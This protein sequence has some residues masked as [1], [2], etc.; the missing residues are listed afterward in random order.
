MFSIPAAED[1]NSKV[2]K[3]PT[4][5]IDFSTSHSSRL[6][7]LNFQC[8]AFD[9]SNSTN[10]LQTRICRYIQ[11]SS[12]DDKVNRKAFILAITFL[13]EFAYPSCSLD[14]P[15][16]VEGISGGGVVLTFDDASI[17]EW[18]AVDSALAAYHWKA[19]FCV[20]GFPALDADHVNKLAALQA[21]GHEIA[22]HGTEHLDAVKYL[23][24]HSAHDYFSKE[25]RPSLDSMKA[26]GIRVQS[27][28]YPYGLRNIESDRVLMGCFSILRGTKSQGFDCL[29]SGERTVYAYEID[30]HPEDVLPHVF[31]LLFY[32]R[33]H[34]EIVIFYAHKP[35]PFGSGENIVNYQ[36]LKEICGFVTSAGM[37]F[38]TLRDLALP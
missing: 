32:A 12:S 37:Q 24:S 3:R 10:H 19:T 35:E 9:I 2:F 4:Y 25:I 38:L 30:G 21:G 14:P 17:D 16:A 26:H 34:D 22:C 31:R 8:S 18:C 5:N 15:S 28:A 29:A 7:D 6:R 1:S 23:S 36:T 11:R 27:F 33:E 20:A 13:L